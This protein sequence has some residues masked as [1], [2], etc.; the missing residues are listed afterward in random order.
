MEESHNRRGTTGLACLLRASLSADL[1]NLTTNSSIRKEKEHWGSIEKHNTRSNS[2]GDN[3]TT[4][5][6]ETST[7]VDAAGTHELGEIRHH[8]STDKKASRDSRQKIVVYGTWHGKNSRPFHSIEDVD[9]LKSYNINHRHP[10]STAK[11][12]KIPTSAGS[13]SWSNCWSLCTEETN[14]QTSQPM[15][16]KHINNYLRQAK[17][18]WYLPIS[19]GRRNVLFV[20]EMLEEQVG[21]AD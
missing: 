10:K 14:H 8:L 15:K 1:T 12:D 21:K 5:T 3:Q 16:I 20:G 19:S 9:T 18:F 17:K 4:E 7:P 11:L 2:A 13:N 6:R